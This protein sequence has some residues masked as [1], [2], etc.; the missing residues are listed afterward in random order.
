MFV[1][2]T[3]YGRIATL[4]EEVREPRTT[5]P[6]AIGLTLWVS[7]ALY[8]GVA[9]VAIAALGSAA[10]AAGVGAGTAPLELAARQF[11]VPHVHIL[12]SL[13]AMTA[14]LGVLLNLIL[15]LSRVVLAM[16]RRGDMPSFL[17]RLNESRTTPYAA[18][19][20]VGLA[21]AALALIGNVKTTWSF[22]AFTVLMYYAITNLAALYL[23]REQRLY[24][25]WLAWA[26]LCACLGLAFWIPWHIW[27][28][29]VGILTLGLVWHV[30]M[31]RRA[32]RIRV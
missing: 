15:G 26:G 23:P 28:T 18:V 7:A 9:A 27:L 20:L 8:L 25:R 2:Y 12:V 24:G 21:V 16:G 31:R 10:L 11:V 29:G 32:S 17:G 5:I 22:S 30:V 6:R 4:G 1:A 3:G 19:V 14:M 13:G